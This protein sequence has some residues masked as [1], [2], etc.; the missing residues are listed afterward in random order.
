MSI[1]V[2]PTEIAL[3]DAFKQRK[4]EITLEPLLVG[5]A[6]IRNDT[7]TVYIFER[8]A[9]GD[10]LASIKDGRY[11]E[12]KS[13]LEKTGVPSKN[14]V[15]IIEQLSAPKTETERKIIWGAICNTEHR[16]KFTVFQTRSIDETVDYLAGM[17]ASIIK[18][19]DKAVLEKKEIDIHIKKHKIT[20]DEWFSCSLALVPGVSLEMA[21][22]ITEKYPTFEALLEQIKKNGNECLANLT[23]GESKR[24]IGKLLSNRIC[25]FIK[26][27]GDRK[28]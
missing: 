6:H 4:I 8:K 5:D 12:Q 1:Y 24:R 21:Q 17:S 28:I 10:L 14:I 7:K 25:S 9:K 13:R 15:Y 26:S 18:F 3:I 22:V 27:N 16:D 20:P 2:T 11:H 19:P 23:H